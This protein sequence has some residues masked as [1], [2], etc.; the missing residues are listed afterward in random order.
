MPPTKK[1]SCS[2]Q[3]NDA[4]MIVAHIISLSHEFIWMVASV[5]PKHEHQTADPCPLESLYYKVTDVEGAKC[6]KNM[7]QTKCL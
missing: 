2:N 3:S 7:V 4:G 1:K 5:T 6:V